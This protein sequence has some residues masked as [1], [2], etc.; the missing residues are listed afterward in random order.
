MGL[1]APELDAAT[2]DAIAGEI[3]RASKH[4][5]PPGTPCPNCGTPLQGPWCHACGQKGEAFH[6]SIWHL[7]AEA[8]EGLTHFDG[9]FWQTL[10]RL[11]LKPGQLTRDYLDGHR[12]S[13][14]PP[15]RLFLVVLLLV[16]FAGGLN[17]GASHQKFKLATL[18]DPQVQAKLTP[19]QKA[20]LESA[21][22][23]KATH[24]QAK[25]INLDITADKGTN[26]YWTAK[27]KHALEDPEALMTAVEQWGHRF[28]VL[29]LPVAALLLTL[30]FAFKKDVYVFDHLIF[31]MHSLS[32]QGLL[33]TAGFLLGMLTDAA[34]QILWLA[35]VHL[36]FHM[37][38]T[39]RSGVVGTLARMTF[40]FFGSSVAVAVLIGALVMVGLAT[41]H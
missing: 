2:A 12:A 30:A 13:Q 15:F 31:S 21:L 17:L 23:E 27:V 3:G 7:A 29:M 1:G 34:W 11:F 25:D 10:P 24:L 28:A 26:A 14:I 6:R 9:R 20:N 40:L 33:V 32:F 35:P 38:G 39:Y 22:G 36:F 16:F 5:L 18:G 8:V 37:R 19:E 4:A 41:M